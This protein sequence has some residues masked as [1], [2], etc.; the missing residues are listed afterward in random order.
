MPQKKSHKTCYEQLI[1]YS[2]YSIVFSRRTDKVSEIFKL[3]LLNF[4]HELSTALV[5]NSIDE[6][7]N[8]VVARLRLTNLCLISRTYT[9]ID[10]VFIKQAFIL[11]CYNNT[12]HAN[13]E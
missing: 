4:F 10:N 3:K 11:L 12:I 7:L 5:E 9:C 6:Y 8:L 2:H 1:F 13:V